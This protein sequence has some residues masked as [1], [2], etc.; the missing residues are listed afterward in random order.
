[1]ADFDDAFMLEL[2]VGFGDGIWVDDERF[3][4]L[5]DARQLIARAESAGFDGVFHLLHELEVDGNAGAV[6]ESADHA[7]GSL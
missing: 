7:K 2:A 5:S 1:M 6:V 4:H 3:G